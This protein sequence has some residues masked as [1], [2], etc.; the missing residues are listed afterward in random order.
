MGRAIPSSIEQSTP[1][2]PGTVTFRLTEPL[3]V[4]ERIEITYSCEDE[5]RVL[6]ERQRPPSC[7]I[8]STHVLTH[9]LMSCFP[10]CLQEVRPVR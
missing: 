10:S 4:G 2:C 9:C 7:R 5:A 3:P 1:L 8:F 6:G